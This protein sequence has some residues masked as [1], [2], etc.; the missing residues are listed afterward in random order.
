V[1]ASR[2]LF[3]VKAAPREASPHDRLSG[4]MNQHGRGVGQPDGACRVNRLG[5]IR[6]IS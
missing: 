1:A 4:I 3:L 5:F 6:R 2:I